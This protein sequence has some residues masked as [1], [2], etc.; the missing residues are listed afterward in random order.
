M[1]QPGAGGDA[2]RGRARADRRPPGRLRPRRA[3][4]RARFAMPLRPGPRAACASFAIPRRGAGRGC[5]RSSPPGASSCSRCFALFTALGLDGNPE[6]GIGARRRGAVRGQRHRG[7]PGD[8]VEHRHLPAGDDQRPDHRLRSH[9]RRRARLR[10]RSC[11]R[12]RSPPRS[13]SVCRRSF[14]RASPGRTCA[15]ACSPRL[16][17]GSARAASRANRGPPEA[18][19]SA[20]PSLSCPSEDHQERL[21]DPDRGSRRNRPVSARQGRRR[22]RATV[23]QPGAMEVTAVQHS[24]EAEGEAATDARLARSDSD[25]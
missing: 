10:S 8:A 6:I 15:C 14:A 19:P 12:S 22:S 4:R 25:A 21:R 11:R 5:S 9:P 23:R 17:S 20:H 16:R 7:D 18:H 13:A 1:R 24:S 3:G 2:G